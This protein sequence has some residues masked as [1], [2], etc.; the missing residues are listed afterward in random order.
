MAKT[1][2]IRHNGIRRVAPAAVVSLTAL[3]SACASYPNAGQTGHFVVTT[4]ED[5]DDNNIGDGDCESTL[6]GNPCTLR[7]AVSESNAMMGANTIKLGSREHRL[8]MVD[9]LTLT[10]PTKIEGDGPNETSI[11]NDDRDGRAFIIDGTPAWITQLTMTDFGGVLLDFGGTVWVD[12]AANLTLSRVRIENGFAFNHAAG[13][14]LT[15]NSRAIVTESAISDN[16]VAGAFGGGVYI[17]EG[18]RLTLLRSTVD[19]NVSNRAGGV[20]NFGELWILDS[21]ISGNSADSDT[22]GTGGVLNIGVVTINNSTIVD[23]SSNSPNDDT[24]SGG[25]ANSGLA[26]VSN[27]IVA[28]NMWGNSENDCNGEIE[29]RGYNLIEETDDCD[30]EGSTTGNITG[31]DPDLSGLAFHAGGPTQTHRPQSGSPAVDAGNP[32]RGSP[33]NGFCSTLDQAL[34]D[35]QLSTSGQRCDIG[36]FESN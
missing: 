28:N 2:F 21:T 35:R 13:L 32:Q 29:S 8:S 36:S 12:E 27:T 1:N 9:D 34:Q 7:A 25:L 24:H 31:Q 5:A 6:S 11:T 18:S 10:G 19:G 20:Y 15:G 3:L 30:I 26:R 16:M 17:Q 14:A 23:N 33:H 22:G 4:G